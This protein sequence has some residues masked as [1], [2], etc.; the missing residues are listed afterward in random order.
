[1]QV[2]AFTSAG[3]GVRS[4]PIHC[5][6]EQDGKIVK[7]IIIIKLLTIKLKFTA[8]EAPVA[9]KALVM[10]SDSILVSWKPPTEPNGIIEQ[11]TVYVQEESP[12][13]VKSHKVIP[14]HRNQN[15][16]FQAKDLDSNLK[17]QFWVTAST[18]IGEGQA[19]KKISV[20]PNTNGNIRTKPFNC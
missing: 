12:D 5:Q 19:S 10:S 11:Y 17:Y 15:L 14:N 2:L 4:Q 6:T 18:N 16:S 8:P 1:M 20:S 13:K 7:Y 3:D 9:I